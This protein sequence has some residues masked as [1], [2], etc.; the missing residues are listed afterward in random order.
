[1]QCIRLPAQVCNQ[2]YRIQK[3]FTRG[4]YCC[5]EENASDQLGTI[6]KPRDAG[7][8]SVHKSD[9]R[10]VASHARHEGYIK[11]LMPFGTECCFTSTALEITI[12]STLPIEPGL[13]L[14]MGEKCVGM[15]ICEG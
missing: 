12:T 1:M 8:L 15:L 3:N 7:G 2:I 4:H 14:G 6:T 13:A 9:F 10:N 5:K 11:T